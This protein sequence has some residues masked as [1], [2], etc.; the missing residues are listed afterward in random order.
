MVVSHVKR[1]NRDLNSSFNHLDIG[2][3]ENLTP[4]I[5]GLNGI[6]VQFHSFSTQQTLK[7]FSPLGNLTTYRNEFH[8]ILTRDF[9][10]AIHRH[11]L[12]LIFWFYLN[13]TSVLDEHFCST[14]VHSSEIPGGKEQ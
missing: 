10:E 12:A 6:R 2:M 7:Q 9:I 4:D 5:M 11:P 14:S 1:S 13:G 8:S 3:V